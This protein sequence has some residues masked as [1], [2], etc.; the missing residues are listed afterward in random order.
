MTR[1]ALAGQQLLIDR[2]RALTDGQADIIRWQRQRIAA[3][4]D[5]VRALESQA[6]TDAELLAAAHRAAPW[7]A[8]DAWPE[9]VD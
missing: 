5:L 3:L 7:A 4:V 6:A 1:A 2:Y 8:S 9:R